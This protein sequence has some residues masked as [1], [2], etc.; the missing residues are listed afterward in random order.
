[1]N[2]STVWSKLELVEGN[3]LLS[4]IEIGH[5]NCSQINA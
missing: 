1:M 4:G 5:E 3:L 2:S